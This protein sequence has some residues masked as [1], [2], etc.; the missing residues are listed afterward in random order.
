MQTHNKCDYKYEQLYCKYKQIYNDIINI[1][2]LNNINIDEDIKDVNIKS[3]VNINISNTSL[4]Q[5]P[6]VKSGKEIEQKIEEDVNEELNINEITLMI[7]L[8]LLNDEQYMIPNDIYD[9]F[10]N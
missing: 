6:E 9:D 7:L 10:L 8:D 2:K 3:N 5:N 4:L 1:N